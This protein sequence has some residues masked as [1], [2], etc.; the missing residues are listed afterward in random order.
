MVKYKSLLT[1]EEAK[2]AKVGY[3]FRW[4]LYGMLTIL[5][6]L[7]LL[8]P[9]TRDEA[10][11][12]LI[13]ITFAALYNLYTWYHIKNNKSFDFFKYLIVFVDVSFVSLHI[14]RLSVNVSVYAISTT[15]TAFIYFIMIFLSVL[16]FDKKLILFSTI[17]SVIYFVAIY[18]IFSPNYN[19]DIVNQIIS[20]NLSGH[21]FKSTYILLFG[22]LLLYIPTTLL[23]ILKK[24]SKSLLYQKE[25]EKKLAL[26]QQNKEFANEK[27]KIEKENNSVLSQ[28]NE[29]L[30]QL[31]EEITAQRDEIFKQNESLKYAYN[32]INKKNKQISA[33]INYACRIQQSILPQNTDLELIP[34]QFSIFYKPRDVVSGDFYW[35]QTIDNSWDF[36]MDENLHIFIC[37]DCTGHGVPGAFM[38]IIGKTLLDDIILN[39]QVYS[40]DMIL[41]QLDNRV[42]RMLHTGTGNQM[43]NDGMDISIVIF[44]DKNSNIFF[45]G[46]RQDLTIV[47]DNKLDIIKGD[48]ESIGGMSLKKQKIKKFTKKEIPKNNNMKLFMSSD[49]FKDQIGGKKRRKY[50]AK[51]FS[52]LLLNF[53][54]DTISNLN[55]YLEDEFLKFTVNPANK[56]NIY[57]QVDD[58]LVIG[59]VIS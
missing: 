38:T 14:Y 36:N 37:A 45:A 58:I 17:L 44:D 24:H 49:G 47:V 7:L 30:K 40:P 8:K 27:L 55:Q 2:G 33:S 6:I 19:Q 34:Y 25:T 12:N 39:K 1:E 9:Q 32:I 53:K 22:L 15:A 5:S 51:N 13:I 16:F 56:A 3:Y 26:E 28:K 31:T 48:R 50:L 21:I 46:A 29:E 4:F 35:I 42:R 59:I 11:G 41:T 43:L 52:N 57:E 20:A 54:S 10:I 23:R 18:I